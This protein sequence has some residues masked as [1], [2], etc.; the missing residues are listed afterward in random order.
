MRTQSRAEL[1]QLYREKCCSVSAAVK[2]IRPRDTIAAPIASGQPAAFLAGLAERDDFEDLTIFTGLIIEPYAVLQ[3]PGVRLISGFYGPIERMLK[4]AGAR[5]DYLPADFLGWERY[6]RLAKPRV[7]VSALAAMDERGFFSF[8]LHA[9]A[10]FNA[11]IEA[12]RD[13]E[14]LAIGEVYR[15]MPRVL[16][17]GRYG[18]HRIH[19]SEIDCLIESDRSVFEL[20]EVL[21]AEEDRIIAAQV[22]SLIEDGATLQFGIGGVPNL[23]ATFL[24]EG[25]KG[26]F[27]IHSEMIVDGIMQ[28]HQA[29][30]ITNHKGIYDGF[31]IGTFAAGSRALYDWMADNH[32]VRLLPV[33]Q[34]NDPAVIRQNRRMTSV[35][36]AL[37]VDVSGQV[38]ADTI[39]SRQYSGVGGHELFVI[40]AH[41][42]PE[43]RSIICLH[44]TVQLKSGER[45]STI[46]PALAAGTRIS[47]PR[48]HVQYVITEHGIANLSM[49]TD[50][51]RVE[52]LVAIA[53]PDLRA[54]LRREASQ[55]A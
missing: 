31:S 39:G 28:L 17:L 55:S 37:A 2:R 11:F 40:G 14:R 4:A 54:Q 45:V 9:G 6:A 1:E 35:N 53:H 8:G 44:S 25:Q 30:K 19:V 24:A 33:A 47:T 42:S 41:D 43:G 10:S 20:P 36:G 52:A 3:Q 49:L 16:G 18:G 34:V 38:M 48:H 12:A 5:I 13:P 46:V 22:E 26:D 15:D 7:V 29:G 21:P 51:E 32:Q 50:R 27:G 23:V